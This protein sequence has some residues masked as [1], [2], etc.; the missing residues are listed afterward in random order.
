[1]H[2]NPT[3]LGTYFNLTM[4]G[5]CQEYKSGVDKSRTKKGSLLSVG[6]AKRDVP[7]FK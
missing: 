1:M 4:Q 7:L 5:R 2:S 3:R 6:S